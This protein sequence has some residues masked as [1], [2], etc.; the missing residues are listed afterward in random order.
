MDACDSPRWVLN[1]H[2]A[3]QFPKL[4]R[5]CLSSAPDGPP[6]PWRSA[7]SLQTE[8]APCPTH[9]GLGAKATDCSS[10]LGPWRNSSHSSP[11][12]GSFAII[13]VARVFRRNLGASTDMQMG[14]PARSKHEWVRESD[15]EYQYLRNVTWNR[16]LFS[17]SWSSR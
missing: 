3:A 17:G 10:L 7:S 13:Y 14:L 5:F 1:E 9:H 2:S 16:P 6:G 4:L 15:P 8:S 11:S 12:D